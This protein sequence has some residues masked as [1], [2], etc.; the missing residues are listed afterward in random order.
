MAIDREVVQEAPDLE[1]SIAAAL[2]DGY[3]RGALAGRGE[4]QTEHDA[5]MEAL[6][7]EFDERLA[8][9]RDQWLRNFSDKA[10]DELS[11]L[12]TELAKTLSDQVAVVLE[13]LVTKQLR[14]NAV[15]SLVTAVNRAIDVGSNIRIL[16]PQELV[17]QIKDGLAGTGANCDWEISDQPEI[18]LQIDDTKIQLAFETWLA[19]LQG[20]AS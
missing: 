2:A 18:S 4:F 5:E 3:A 8:T 9:A 10:I 15:T 16:A 17:Q 7:R 6:K 14:D 11:R 19:E 13:P 20:E 1:A 12:K